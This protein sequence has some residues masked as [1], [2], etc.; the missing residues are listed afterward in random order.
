MFASQTRRHTSI[1]RSQLWKEPAVR[2][3]RPIKVTAVIIRREVV[4][5]EEVKVGVA[6]AKPTQ[7]VALVAVRKA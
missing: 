1:V 5:K 2:L 3:T 4:A 6:R 7:G